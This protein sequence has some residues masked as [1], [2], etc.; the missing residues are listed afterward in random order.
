VGRPARLTR[1][2]LLAAGLLAA[3]AALA[4]G[5][6]AGVLRPGASYDNPLRTSAIDACVRP[7]R[8]AGIAAYAFD[9]A[10]LPFTLATGHEPG[11][12]PRCPTGELRILTLAALTIDGQPAYVRRGG[13]AEPCRVRQPTV[14]LLARDLAGPVRL[15]PPSARGGDGAPAPACP[16]AAHAAPGL[17]GFDLGQMYYKTPAEIR[18]THRRT[19]VI[20]P[21]ARWSNYGDPGRRFRPRADYGYL[22]WNLPRRASGALLPGGGIVEAVIAQGDPVALCAVA[23]LTLPSFDARGAGN[24]YVVF[25]YARTANAATTIYGWLLL[26]YRHGDRP[27]R[28]TTTA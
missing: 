21:G 10:R 14:H 28:A 20:G 2:V 13:C 8:P 22:L 12:R 24:G 7:T 27:F 6:T 4:P 25:G 26:G 16:R 17:A 23:P 19:G 18:G 3:G 9:G 11:T 5:R 1:W 15:L